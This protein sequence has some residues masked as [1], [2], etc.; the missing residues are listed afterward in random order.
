MVVGDANPHAILARKLAS[1]LQIVLP[2]AKRRRKGLVVLIETIQVDRR[3]LD[4]LGN[5]TPSSRRDIPTNCR[6]LGADD[7]DFHSSPLESV[8]ESVITKCLGQSSPG[9][10]CCQHWTICAGL[11]FSANNLS[12]SRSLSAEEPLKCSCPLTRRSSREDASETDCSGFESWSMLRE[13]PWRP[14]RSRRPSSRIRAE[15][16]DFGSESRTVAFRRQWQT[17]ARWMQP[18]TR[19]SIS[20]PEPFGLRADI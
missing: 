15:P 10:S 16:G 12:S 13:A 8:P 14:L 11:D 7:F 6:V 5:L 1:P 20:R 4:F 9:N 3:T 17:R 2:G 19:F 18:S